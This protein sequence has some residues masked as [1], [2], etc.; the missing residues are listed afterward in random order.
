MNAVRHSAVGAAVGESSRARDDRGVTLLELIAAFSVVAVL[1][2]LA[3]LGMHE[4]R[5]QWQLRS[6]TRQVVLD[7]RMARAAAI[8]RARTHRLRFEVATGHYWREVQADDGDFVAE[9][10]ARALP[11]TVTIA[12]CTARNQS[13][14]FRPRGNAATFGTISLA[15]HAGESRDIVVDMVGRVQVR[16]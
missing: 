14:S 13:V 1:L 9:S 11:A 16:R 8:A 6:A 2:G 4:L 3:G 15:G 12:A 7:L 10:T 5:N